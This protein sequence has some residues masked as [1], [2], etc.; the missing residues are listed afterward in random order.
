MRTPNTCRYLREG[1]L[2][3]IE[4]TARPLIE[5]HVTAERIEYLG[6]DPIVRRL[7]RLLG[8][9]RDEVQHLWDDAKRLGWEPPGEPREQ[10]LRS[11]RPAQLSTRP[12]SLPAEAILRLPRSPADLERSVV[13]KAL[14]GDEAA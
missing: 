7:N 12:R 6:G 2:R 1:P 5:S 14:A 11:L 4:D 13:A 8:F 10:D 9:F 3:S